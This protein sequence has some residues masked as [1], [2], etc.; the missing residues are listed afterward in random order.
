[1]TGDVRGQCSALDLR[2]LFDKKTPVIKG[3]ISFVRARN[4]TKICNGV[5]VYKSSIMFLLKE[6][7]TKLGVINYFSDS[8]NENSDLRNLQTI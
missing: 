3:Y 6:Q 4:K 8:T 2:E 7:S 1:M 5:N